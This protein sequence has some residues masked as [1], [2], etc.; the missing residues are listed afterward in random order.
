MNKPTKRLITVLIVVMLLGLVFYPRLKEL[1]NADSGPEVAAEAPKKGGGKT[2]VSVMVVEPASLDDVVKTTGSILAN[3]EVEIRSEVPGKITNLY[4][5]EGQYVSKGTTLLKI[6]DDD[7]Q[8]QLKK[9]E[10]NKKLSEDN[11]FRQRRLLE[12]EAISQREYDISLT[13]VKTNEAD[14]DNIKAQL[15][16]TTIKAPF[17]GRLGLRYISE[18]SYVTPSSRITTLTNTNPAKVEFSVPAKYADKIKVGSTLKYTTESSD[19][20]H[21]GRVYAV[22]PKID[23]QTRTL[24][25]RATSPNPKGTLL[26]GAFA[27]IELIT[28]TKGTA[29]SIPNEAVIPEQDGHKVFVVK[30]GLATPR[31]VE[32]GLRGE[33]EMEI[34]AGLTA[35]DT[36]ITTGILQVKPGG[37][38][39]IQE[40]L[41][42]KVKS[43]L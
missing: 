3:E 28:G 10:Y 24:Q 14:I 40:T 34:L 30:D 19:Q 35:G 7:L 2:I 5:K 33:A 41:R 15:T 1:F 38:V 12:K 37:A 9:L 13:T 20:V 25:M 4:F 11:E 26:P 23:P 31:P 39:E 29:I 27:R 43:T 36:L 21:T 42:Q 22:D 17:S 32:V 6:Y 8:A 18:G 16:K